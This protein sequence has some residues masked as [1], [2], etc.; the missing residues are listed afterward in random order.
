MKNRKFGIGTLVL[1]AAAAMFAGIMTTASFD[2]TRTSE[3]Q[4]FWKEPSQKEDVALSPRSFVELSKKLAPS[5]V[6]ISTTQVTR[7]RPLMPFPEF[8]TPF[9]DGHEFK[10][11]SL[12]SGFVINK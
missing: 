7:Q 8:K 1:A 6:N 4:N 10:R 2:F 5:V 11:Q 3:A 12:G 9:D